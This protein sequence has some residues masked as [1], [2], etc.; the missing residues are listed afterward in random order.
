[1]KPFCRF[2]V[3]STL[4]RWCLGLLAGGLSIGPFCATA[5]PHYKLTILA[6][7][8]TGVS[9][10]N[11]GQ[12]AGYRLV[13]P[14]ETPTPY[15][16]EGGVEHDIN[17]LY[18]YPIQI[19]DVGQFIANG[20]GSGNQP[21]PLLRDSNGK[22]V[23]LPYL[24]GTT[25]YTLWGINSG[26]TVVGRDYNSD[27]SVS[28]GFVYQNNKISALPVIQSHTFVSAHC[29]NTAGQIVAQYRYNNDPNQRRAAI[30]TGTQMQD[31]GTYSGGTDIQPFAM[32]DNDEVVGIGSEAIE[33]G[34]IVPSAFL[35]SGGQIQPVG[36]WIPT[37]INN[38]SQVVG[39]K[40]GNGGLTT[41]IA[42]IYTGGALTDLNTLI[43]PPESSVH[44]YQP[45]AINNS[46]QILALCWVSNDVHKEHSCVL[47]PQ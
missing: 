42:V 23:E 44:I 40:F 38:S 19:N 4:T 13:L 26:G 33:N 35:Y 31:L 20:L 6:V 14:T 46:D 2:S 5:Q 24:K 21:I 9:M 34:T 25:Q 41:D 37:G 45:L 22:V 7:H 27:G 17:S 47:T 39:Y 18:C 36:P 11:G 12:I 8:G 15:I 10:N 32:N 43:E 3:R 16:F 28:L 29:I 30:I 1:M